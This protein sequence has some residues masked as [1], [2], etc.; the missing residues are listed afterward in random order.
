MKREDIKPEELEGLLVAFA[1]GELDEPKFSQVAELISEHSDLAKKVEEYI[2]TGDHLKDFFD[3][4]YVKAPAHVAEQI[5]QIADKAEASRTA[6]NEA[7]P[8][9][10]GSNVI[11]FSRF[12]KL[13]SKIPISIQSLTQM[14]AALTV[15]IFLGPSLLEDQDGAPQ[16]RS[17]GID[18]EPEDAFEVSETFKTPVILSII[19]DLKGSNFLTAPHIPPGGQIQSGTV[20]KLWINPPMSGLLRIFEVSS[21]GSQSSVLKDKI[22]S[23][24]PPSIDILMTHGTLDTLPSAQT[25]LAKHSIPYYFCGHVHEEHGVQIFHQTIATNA[26]TMSRTDDNKFQPSNPPV[27]MDIPFSRISTSAHGT[28]YL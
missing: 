28:S 26:S 21:D 27:V 18:S 9:P 10:S 11:N 14:A 1:D 13:S 16:Y 17:V 2:Y 19:Q 25:L 24:V 7:S 20:F 15:G 6:A 23:I 4:Q 5:L 3:T 8:E 22:F 12:K